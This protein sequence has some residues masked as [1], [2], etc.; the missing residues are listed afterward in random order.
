LFRAVKFF[1]YELARPGEERSGF[2]NGGDV[3][4]GLLAELLAN[5]GESLTLGISVR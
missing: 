3:S 2:D 5:L 4:E 1:C